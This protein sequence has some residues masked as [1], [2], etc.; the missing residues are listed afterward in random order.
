MILID[1]TNLTLKQSLETHEAMCRHMERLME[2]EGWQLIQRK[3]EQD[4]KLALAQI[5]TAQTSDARSVA[6]TG[7]ATL[8]SVHSM[9]RDLLLQ[10]S[11]RMKQIVAQI[12]HEQENQPKH[13]RDGRR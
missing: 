11:T 1:E 13:H 8:E 9:P 10:S 7:Y 4:M 5:R 12:Q 3:L 6:A 2:F